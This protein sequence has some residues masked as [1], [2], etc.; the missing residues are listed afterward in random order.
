M[1]KNAISECLCIQGPTP[2]PQSADSKRIADFAVDLH[3]TLSNQVHG[4][5]WDTNAVVV[6]DEL[7]AEARCVV[8]AVCK[9]LGLS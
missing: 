9:E 6:S 3:S 4:T 1:L 7:S 8:L 5:P 2:A